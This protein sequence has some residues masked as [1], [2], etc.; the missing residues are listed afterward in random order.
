MAVLAV[1]GL[2]G[3]VLGRGGEDDAAAPPRTATGA[4]TCSGEPGA[5][6]T[7]AP[8]GPAPGAVDVRDFGAVGDGVTDDAPAIRRA[9]AAATAV[10]VPAGSYLLD[11]FD[12]PRTGLVTADF[13]FSL[14]SGQ[15]LTADPG[16]VFRMADGAVTGSSAA[17][18]GNVFLAPAVHDIVISGL[19]LDLNG[20]GNLVPAGRVITGYGL[21]AYDSEHVRLSDVTMLDTPGQ[22]YVVAQGGGTDIR[23]ERSTFRNGGTS[24]PGNRNQ[25]DFSALYFTA[26]DVVVDQVTIEHDQPPFDFSGGVELH[27]SRESVTASRVEQ[28]WPAVYIGPDAKAGGPVQQD[29]TVACN[30]FTDVGRGVVFNAGGTKPI[31]GVRITQNDV[32]LARFDAFPTEPTRGIDQDMPTEPAWTYHHVITGLEVDRN[33]IT[34]TDGTSDAAVRLSQVQGATITGNDLRGTSRAALELHSSPWG[35]KNVTFERN[36]VEWLGHAPA[37]ALSLGGRSTDPPVAA[38]TADD[39]TVAHNRISRGDGRS[40]RCAI[41]ADWN[42]HAGVSAVRAYG[43][44]VAGDTP[45]RCGPRAAQLQGSP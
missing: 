29:V 34:D 16:A 31:D 26:T 44:T 13:V 36:T 32:E 28:S 8:A 6:A 17:W 38:F 45:G 25:D 9:L 33:R 21:Y 24:I 2:L 5:P 39:I 12:S 19:T 23:V 30:S 27:G 3:W 7:P 43:N 10:H 22:N 15:V 18:G 4:P 41:Y 1:V 14:R 11:S 37:V 42:A 20:P 40:G 35:T